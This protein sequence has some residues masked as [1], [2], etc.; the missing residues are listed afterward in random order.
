MKRVIK[1]MTKSNSLKPPFRTKMK[2][3]LFTS[4]FPTHLFL[5]KNLSE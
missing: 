4:T 1:V 5:P 2:K 3:R